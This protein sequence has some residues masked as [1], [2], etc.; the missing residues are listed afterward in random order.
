MNLGEVFY[1]QMLRER[2]VEAIVDGDTRRTYAE[3]YEDICAV[4]GGLQAAA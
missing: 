3:W 1:R 2:N 4:A